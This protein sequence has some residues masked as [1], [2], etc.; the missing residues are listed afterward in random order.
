M[1]HS[2]IQQEVDQLAG[3]VLAAAFASAGAAVDAVDQDSAEGPVE[4]LAEVQEERRGVVVLQHS[5]LP[6]PSPADRLIS[7]KPRSG[8]R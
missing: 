3:L 2:D 8:S 7:V 1:E 4:G 5:C 6:Y